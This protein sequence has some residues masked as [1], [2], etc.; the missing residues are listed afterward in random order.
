MRA[1]PSLALVALAVLAGCASKRG[2]PDNEPTIAT[3]NQRAIVVTPDGGIKANTAQTIAA[4]RRFLE[5]TPQARETP[6]ALRRLGDLEM[7]LADQKLADGVATPGGTADY[8]VATAQ[9]EALLKQFPKAPGNDR[10]LYQLSRAHEQGGALEVALATLDRLV[11]EHPG[12]AYRD[13]AQFRRGELLFTMRDYPRAEKAYATVL[14]SG[15]TTPYTERALYMQGWSMFKQGRL[16]DALGPFFGVLDRTI[17]DAGDESDLAKVAGLSR[18]DRELV[19]DTFRVASLS[20]ANLQGAESIAPYNDSDARRG[21]E[22]RVYQQLGELYLKQE[23][24]KDAADTL[25]LFAKRQPLHAQAPVLQA[26]VIDIYQK[27]GFATLALD[28]KRQYVVQYGSEGAFRRANPDGWERAQPLVKTHLAE[29]AQHHHALAQKSKQASDVDDAARWYRSY[30]VS[31]PK[32]EATPQ[33]AFLLGELM[34]DAARYGD[35]STAYEQSAYDYP[36]HAKSADAGYAALLGHAETE[37]RASAADKPATQRAGLQSGLRFADTFADD[38]R[39]TGV[40]SNA[41][42]RLYAVGDGPSAVNVAKQVLARPQATPAE[43]RVAWTVVSHTALDQGAFADAERGYREVLAL[44]PERDPARADLTERLAAAVYKQ[45]EQAQKAGQGRDAV[46]HYERVAALAP[47]SS[48]AA[49]AQFD[50][51]TAMIGLKDWDGAAR[52]LEDF[53]QRFASNNLTGEV[54]G[55]LAV[56]HLERGQWGLA[57]A[58]FEKLAATQPDPELARA[59]LWQAAELYDKAAGPGGSRSAS[60]RVYERYVQRYPSPLEPA[61]EARWRLA[62]IAQAE[63]NAPKRLALLR[64][65][66]LA[67]AGGGSARTPRT[68][69]IGGLATLAL[70]EPVFEAYRAVPLNEPLAR[71]LRLKKAKM[72]D[73]LKA[74]AQASEY[75]VAEVTTAATFQTASVYQDFGKSMLGS[76]RPKHL[77]KAALEQYNVLLE[78]QAFPFEEKAIELH[79]VNARRTADGLWN[80]WIGKSFVALAELRPVRYRKTERPSG[81][82]LPTAGS[83]LALEAAALADGLPGSYNDLGIAWRLAGEFEKARSAY[84]R[85]IAIDPGHVAAHLNLGILHDLYLRDPQRAVELYDRAQALMQGPDATV[86]KWITD[87]RNRK[88][89]QSLLS[90]KEVS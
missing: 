64:D 10:V 27:N 37:K 35:A 43:R 6:E 85:A 1:S 17:A 79:E 81:S 41:A 40:L 45:G 12:T 78:E 49:A 33:K 53:R 20:L 32:D 88:P 75:G 67:D 52:V 54:S 13:E 36:R 80:E 71:Q 34:F 90:K 29:L 3:L 25:G 56:V 48:V 86:A 38:P 70:A 58:E 74:Y 51:A 26:Q 73:V 23:R 77:R 62:T 4:Y 57:A 15:D 2:S 8:K 47:T 63:R 50:A 19:D 72:E 14:A 28:A 55:K 5:V 69:A 89:P 11:A 84:E 61:M 60:V 30:I 22:F 87:L 24:T 59:A 44:V 7:D 42:E 82:N 16:E 68:Q 39:A 21:Y 9:Y 18:A 65:A 66:R 83:A 76:Q 31:F 46:G